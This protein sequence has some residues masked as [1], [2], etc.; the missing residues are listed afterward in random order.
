MISPPMTRLDRR[1][2]LSLLVFKDRTRLCAMIDRMAAGRAIEEASTIR[3]RMNEARMR[4]RQQKN[5]NNNNNKKQTIWRRLRNRSEPRRRSF[6][7]IK[8]ALDRRFGSRAGS[9]GGSNKNANR[10]SRCVCVVPPLSARR[11]LGPVI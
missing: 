4:P 10:F 11:R 6:L 1:I 7:F 2:T 5:N 9:D 3:S 8:E